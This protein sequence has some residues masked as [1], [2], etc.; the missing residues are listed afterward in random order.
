MADVCI[1]T[2]A[3]R[4]AL[5]S[6][7]YSAMKKTVFHLTKRASASCDAPYNVTAVAHARNDIVRKE[8]TTHDRTRCAQH[9]KIA[10][11]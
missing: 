3:D 11:K 1:S 5:H 6:V 2:V 8:R 7:Y 10:M 4:H 9:A